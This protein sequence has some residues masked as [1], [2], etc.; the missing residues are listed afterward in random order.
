MSEQYCFND[1]L[2]RMSNPSIRS[3]LCKLRIGNNKLNY[4]VGNKFNKLK[5]CICSSNE[6]ET[7]EHVLLKC[8]KYSNVR[9]IF[10]KSVS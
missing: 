2:D 10:T 3:A 5:L 8:N 9:N 1:Y 4:C 6:D 7:L